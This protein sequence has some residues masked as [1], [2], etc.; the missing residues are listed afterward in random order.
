MNP[1]ERLIGK[2]VNHDIPMALCSFPIS[3]QNN[4]YLICSRSRE[5][6]PSA[7]TTLIKA[8]NDMAVLIRWKVFCQLVRLLELL[9]S[10]MVAIHHILKSL[11]C[12]LREIVVGLVA[13]ARAESISGVIDVDLSEARTCSISSLESRRIMA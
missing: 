10:W 9:D 2:T 13:H 8:E 6:V 7:A 12:P 5:V 4:C 1:H 3:R 11:H